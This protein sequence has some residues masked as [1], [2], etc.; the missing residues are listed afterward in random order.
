[1]FVCVRREWDEREEKIR[2]ERE[3]KRETHKYIRS[4][5][6]E[7][8]EQLV[9]FGYLYRVSPGIQFRALDSAAGNLTCKVILLSQMLAF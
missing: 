9:E 7:V 6:M 8:R 3:K 4:I 1:M 2:G 5:Y